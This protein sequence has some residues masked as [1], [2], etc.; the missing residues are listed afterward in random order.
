MTR[1]KRE[2][3][4]IEAERAVLGCALIDESV[5]D[6]IGDLLPEQF[7]LEAHRKIFAAILALRAVGTSID[8]L[9]VSG[10]LEKRGQLPDVGG[11]SAI[12]ALGEAV[13][14]STGARDY[15]ALVMA[16]YR[17]RQVIEAADELS[18][19][20]REDS[21]ESGLEERAR[22]LQ[23]L[24]VAPLV[25][26]SVVTLEQGVVE[27]FDAKDAMTAEYGGRAIPT[28]WPSLDRLLNGG[29]TAGKRPYWLAAPTGVGKTAAA[30]QT[31]LWAALKLQIWVLLFSL[32]M[33]REDV[34]SRAICCW[35]KIE[36]TGFERWVDLDPD[37]QYR[38]IQTA[39]QVMRGRMLIDASG[40]PPK[41]TPAHRLRRIPPSYTLA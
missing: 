5:L 27:L 36:R 31:A 13:P 17:R 35:G 20:A 37:A 30:V 7:Y 41:G 8:F 40:S 21:D 38:A 26:T 22:R 4:N 12:S 19:A 14:V 24:A 25:A 3:S 39:E 23:D 34:V 29:W 15:A 28:G 16:E 1:Q 33:A 9:T 2:R 6:Q 11:I 32:E 18:H 10:E